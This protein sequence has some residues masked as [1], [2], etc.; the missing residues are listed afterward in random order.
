MATPGV[1]SKE[2]SALVPLVEYERFRERHPGYGAVMWFINT[3]LKNYNDLMDQYPELGSEVDASIKN[4][5]D[6][7]RHLKRLQDGAALEVETTATGA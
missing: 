1:P 3:A 5:V 2:F 4:M 7:N 6:L